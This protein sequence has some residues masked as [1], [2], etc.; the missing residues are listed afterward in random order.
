MA[1]NT[2]VEEYTQEQ[3]YESIQWNVGVA[4]MSQ[5]LCCVLTTQHWRWQLLPPPRRPAPQSRRPRSPSQ[6]RWCAP[7]RTCSQ[8]YGPGSA[9][10]WRQGCRGV[11]GLMRHRGSSECL[12]LT[13]YRV[14]ECVLVVRVGC[15]PENSECSSLTSTAHG[16]CSNPIPTLTPEPHH[17][18][19]TTNGTTH[20]PTHPPT[21]VLGFRWALLPHHVH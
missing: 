12:T 13:L 19:F 11:Q 21:M 18:P 15:G 4:G 14:V 8:T 9:Q 16:K 5:K 20:P 6:C 2:F 7:G 17:Q 10:T 3:Y 1:R